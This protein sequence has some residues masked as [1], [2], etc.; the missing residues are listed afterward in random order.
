MRL[1]ETLA[2]FGALWVFLGVGLALGALWSAFACLRALAGDPLVLRL[3][4]APPFAL[5]WLLATLWAVDYAYPYGFRLWQAALEAAGA[6]LF[7]LGPGGW[8]RERVGTLRR[9]TVEKSR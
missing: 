6:A 1:F 7:C 2:Q 4:F 3:I 9:R 5:F 8:L